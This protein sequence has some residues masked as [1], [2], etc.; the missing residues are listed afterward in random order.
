MWHTQFSKRE[1]LELCL[2]GFDRLKFPATKC[3]AVVPGEGRE[4]PLD[5]YWTQDP[6]SHPTLPTLVVL[7]DDDISELLNA[8]H[9]SPQAPTPFTALV[10]VMSRN[11]ALSYFG[12]SNLS[13]GENVM[14]A[15]VALSMV[16]AVLHSDGRLNLKQVGPATC[17]R[18]MSFAWGRAIASGVPASA[19]AMLPSRWLETYMMINPGGYPDQVRQTVRCAFSALSVCTEIGMGLPATSIAGQLAAA[20]VEGNDVERESTW[21]KLSEG[22]SET[23]TL[24][25]LARL[26]REERVSYLQ[27][28]LR[29]VSSSRS[30]DS[31]AAVCA[32]LAT[33]VAPGSLEHI[34]ILKA[35]GNP[36]VVFWYALFAA[37]QSPGALMNGQSGLGF[38][39]A[40]D[41]SSVE[42]H[43]QSPRSDV[44]YRELMSVRRLGVESL[45]RK[46]SHTGEIQVELL[47]LVTSSFAFQNRSYKAAPYEPQAPLDSIALQVNPPVVSPK[48]RITALL[49]EIAQLVSSLPKETSDVGMQA[50]YKR[51]RKKT[52]PTRPN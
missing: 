18:T 47:P 45:S 28:A 42:E 26:S 11:E 17:R 37:L 23:I 21:L 39:V 4:K 48:L 27:Q 22:T 19:L 20:V 10:N 12:S 38:R 13:V 15:L 40:R 36:S 3:S 24:A 33:Q 49:S 5:V 52:P 35:T 8:L 34:D 51:S 50:T 29:R 30:S 6:D 31:S 46:F 44:S 43:M 1:F 32:F 16:E 7:P 9:A 41:I 25:A 14:P 2:S